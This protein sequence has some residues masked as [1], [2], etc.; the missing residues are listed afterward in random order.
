MPFGNTFIYNSGDLIVN[1]VSGSGDTFLET[2]IN[3][4]TSS[5][6]LFDGNANLTSAS[7]NSI[8]VGTSSLASGS[9]MIATSI[10][11]TS[12]VA[13]FI[14]ASS[15]SSSILTGSVLGTSSVAINA[16]TASYLTTTNNYQVGILTASVVSSSA[17]TA[18]GI[19]VS[20]GLTPFFIKT[21]GANRISISSSG[22]IGFGTAPGV[23][24][25]Y[26]FNNTSVDGRGS[27]SIL[28]TENNSMTTT[29]S[30][31][32]NNG[33]YIIFSLNGTGSTNSSQ[34]QSQYNQLTLARTGS[35]SGSCRAIRTTLILSP[36]NTGS[37]SF[38][39]VGLGL[40]NAYYINQIDPIVTGGTIPKWYGGSYSTFTETTANTVTSSIT[41]L[42]Y[43]YTATPFSAHTAT[44]MSITNGY[45]FYCDSVKT[46]TN[47]VATGFGFY[48]NGT[49]DRNLFRGS[50]TLGGA[51]SQNVNPLGVNGSVGI[52]ST[53]YNTIGPTNGLIVQGNVGIGTTGPS[54]E[55]TVVGTIS[56]SVGINS[57]NITGSIFSGSVARVSSITSSNISASGT[58]S[59]GLLSIG[60]I[61]PASNYGTL[62]ISGSGVGGSVPALRLD[63]VAADTSSAVGAKTF[64]AWVS[65]YISGWSGSLADGTYYIPVYQ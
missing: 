61:V 29:G 11:A 15:I 53:Y 16:Q 50:T 57:V 12:I 18:S 45:G 42:Y 14:T 6:I 19:G 35:Y 23:S 28:I 8:K 44:T 55:L 64:K 5:I 3:A 34:F 37:I 51:T 59:A 25:R 30:S 32:N 49:L 1:V 13:T 21:S 65:V 48:Q 40:I 56:S 58:S 46:S 38:G 24:S 9:S 52:G 22:T 2:K 62:N 27:S 31:G 7:L 43:H 39:S 60:G 47:P 26:T 63:R 36:N 17:I 10:T 4:A 33:I 41:D 20:D 54:N